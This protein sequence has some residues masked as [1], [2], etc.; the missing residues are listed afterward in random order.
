MTISVIKSYRFRKNV[1]TN[2]DVIEPTKYNN[3]LQKMRFITC[4]FYQLLPSDELCAKL[5][6]IRVAEVAS[7][8]PATMK[9]FE[10]YKPGIV[11]SFA[12]LFS[13]FVQNFCLNVPWSFL[14]SH[15]PVY[16]SKRKKKKSNLP[17]YSL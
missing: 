2:L 14:P 16:E 3:L 4:T 6:L 8:K 15:I 5:Q 7:I 13:I 17:L 12:A 1:V 10:Y 9:A 11:T